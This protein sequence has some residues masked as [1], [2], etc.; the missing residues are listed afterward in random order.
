VKL[1]KRVL[2]ISESAT[3]AVSARA[4]KMKA[5]GVDVIDFG[6]GEPDFPTPGFISDAGIEAIKAG[7]TK[8]AHAATTGTAELKKAIISKLKND[9][10]LEYEPGQIIVSCGA[11][12]S[13]FNIILS[14]VE[15][16]DEVIIG[17]PYWVSYPEMVKVA[18]GTPIAVESLQEEGFALS[19]EKLEKAITDKTKLL[20]LNSPC[21]PTGAVLQEKE[22]LEIARVLL[23][24]DIFIISDEIYE[25]LI[26]DGKGH[27]SIAALEPALK[28]RTILINGCSKAYSMTGWRIGYAAGPKEIIAAAARLQSHSTSGANSIGQEAALA[29][30]AGDQSCV[31]AMRSEFDKRRK[32]IVEKLNEIQG[33][34]CI[35][36]EGAFYAF[37]KVSGLYGKTIDGTEIKDSLSLCSAALEKKAVAIVPGIAF[38]A[39]DYV[40]FSYATS[41]E[42]I[43]EGMKRLKEFFQ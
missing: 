18:G 36:P 28:E 43:K 38:G 5:E 29:A 19:A 42:N 31:D 9:N 6:L 14:V 39:D 33:I 13:I 20:I 11:K 37:P 35:M 8:Y 22:L 10:G 21:N 27:K 41:I 25:K 40:R 15:E 12:H 4:K 34:Q 26:Y 16:G 7:K 23:N 24:R 32:F 1:A 3:L 17:C 30:L 2:D